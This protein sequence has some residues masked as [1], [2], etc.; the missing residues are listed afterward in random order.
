MQLSKTFLISEMPLFDALDASEVSEIEKCMLYQDLE[1]GTVV[2][3]QGS[4]GKSV[5]FVV[6]GELAVRHHGEDGEV[7]IATVRRGESVG[8]MAIIDG[9]TRS[10]DVVAATDASVLIL[11]QSDFDALVED[12]PA[13]GVKVLRSLAR[14]MSMTLRDRSAT[15]AKLMD[16]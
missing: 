13:I 14:A 9:L 8:E 10:A 12:Q 11:K 1:R 16:P 2:Y 3:K 5:C 7:Q 15:L 4:C 6:E